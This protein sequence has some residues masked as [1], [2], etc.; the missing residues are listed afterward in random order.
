VITWLQHPNDPLPDTA[1][2]LPEGSDA[3]GLLAGGGEL[4]PARLTEAYRKGVFPWFSKGEPILW[5][6]LAPRMVLPVAEFKIS[7]S[8]RKTLLRFSRTA[9][10]EI[11]INHA[12]GR[13]IN[14][15]AQRPREGHTSSWIVDEM[16]EAYNQWH[17]LGQVHSFETWI[18]GELMGGLYGVCLGRMFYGESMFARGTDA[19][20]IALAALVAFCREHHMPL[21][22][23]QQQTGHLASLGAKPWSRE[24]F[25]AAIA[26]Q[27]EQDPV[28][29]WAYHPAMWR[30]LELGGV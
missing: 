16:I 4:T 6:S 20:K 19:S 5:W 7:R 18:D 13:V 8:L 23:C 22:D 27:I 21:I 26:S 9:T 11:R 28:K 1:T 17:R 10:C 30:H 29:N 12:F 3:P 2:A 14:A 25:E 15:C 24:Q